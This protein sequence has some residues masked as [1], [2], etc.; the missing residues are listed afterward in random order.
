MTKHWEALKKDVSV[1][2]DIARGGPESLFDLLEL[3][4]LLPSSYLQKVTGL[5]QPKDS[6]PTTSMPEEAHS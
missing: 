6:T 1:D 3:A 5:T 2:S 4:D